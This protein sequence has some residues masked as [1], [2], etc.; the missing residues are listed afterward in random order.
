MDTLTEYHKEC[1]RVYSVSLTPQPPQK[2]ASV[3][4]ASLGGEF[5]DKAKSARFCTQ[6]V[7][8]EGECGRGGLQG[9]IELWD[10]EKEA[11]GEGRPFPASEPTRDINRG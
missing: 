3:T 8:G 6:V 11:A 9:G 5:P 7:M 10:G 4:L 1:E 2:K